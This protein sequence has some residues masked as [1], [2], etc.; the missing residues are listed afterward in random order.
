[1]PYFP[2]HCS[3]AAWLQKNPFP[4][5]AH[6]ICPAKM[7]ELSLSSRQIW[8]GK[9]K[10]MG[11]LCWLPALHISAAGLCPQHQECCFCFG[12]VAPILGML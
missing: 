5:L 6:S 8:H 12:D 11:K 9:Q 7:H 4:T 3:T 10:G 1:M 2:T